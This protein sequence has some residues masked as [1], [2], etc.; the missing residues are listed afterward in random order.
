M[1]PNVVWGALLGA[2]LAYETYALVSKKH[3]DTLSERTRAWFH[4]NTRVGKL[5]F[6][7]TWLSF[8][9]WYFVHILQGG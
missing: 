1:N 9:A 4:T 2:G 5:A 8:A 7:I 6:A 3:G